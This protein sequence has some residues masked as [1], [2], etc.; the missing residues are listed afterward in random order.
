LIVAFPPAVFYWFIIHPFIGYWRRLGARRTFLLVL[1]FLS[2]MGYGIVLLRRPLLS[3]EFGTNYY[4]WPL[5]LLCYGVAI[6][7]ERQLRRHLKFR[8]LVGVPELD[9]SGKG[10][11][12]LSEG[13]YGRMRHP[14]YVAIFLTML[15]WSFFAN[16][17][18]T[19]IL[20]PLLSLALYL[21][22][23]L[24]ERELRQRFGHAH[25]QYCQ[26]VPRFLPKKR[27]QAP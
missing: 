10:G 18:A 1:P 3:V 24:E 7:T 22:T 6:R 8:S 19:Y 12:L 11:K 27:G 15:A 23:L 13:I 26:Q 4:L 20:V 2:L 17:L 25:A 16:Y 5:V 14:R 9:R 21:V